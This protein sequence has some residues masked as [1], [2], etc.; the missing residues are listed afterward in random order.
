MTACPTD[1][2]LATVS[3]DNVARVWDLQEGFSIATITHPGAFIPYGGQPGAQN[4]IAIRFTPD[5]RRLVST[6][7][8]STVELD[9]LFRPDEVCEKARARLTHSFSET[10]RFLFFS[11][12]P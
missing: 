11:N 6:G 5:G 3:E 10:E 4:S 8:H 9:W 2:Y 12:E 1:L 7:S